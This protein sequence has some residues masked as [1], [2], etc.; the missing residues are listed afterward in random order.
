[1]KRAILILWIIAITLALIMGYSLFSNNENVDISNNS[2]NANSI[3]Q[4]DS[5]PNA[6]GL[7]W[8]H[9]PVTYSFA[10]NFS[11]GRSEPNYIIKAF[12]E[13]QNETNKIVRFEQVESNGDIAIN[14]KKD[15]NM[16][17]TAGT[18]QVGDA[19]ISNLEGNRIING[20]LNF[21]IVSN[22]INAGSCS[23]ADIEVHEILH[24][25]G[26]DHT[27]EKN[28]IMNPVVSYCPTHLNEDILNKLLSTYNNQ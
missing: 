4:S 7:H 20:E 17:K 16:N 19:L 3:L 15:F 18:Y 28:N 6:Q 11:C 10:D 21:Y 2:Q 1:M 13:I 9:M 23:Y 8:T 5:F 27:S 24:T 26:F 12:R 25:F 22:T 14:C